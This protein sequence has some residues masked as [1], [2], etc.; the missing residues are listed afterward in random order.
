MTTHDLVVWRAE[1]RLSQE[2]LAK[3]L[4]C[5]QAAVSLWERTHLPA[6]IESRLQA[7]EMILAPYPSCRTP[8]ECIRNGYCT[9]PCGAF[10]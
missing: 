9:G 8:K 2:R 1:R 10:D 5:T 7:A 4:G 6:D 3:A